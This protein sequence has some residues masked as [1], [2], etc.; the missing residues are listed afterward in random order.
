MK[1]VNILFPNQLFQ[2]SP[3][4]ENNAPFYLVEEFLFFKQYPFHKQKIA[5]HRA[6]MKRY[7]D[8]LQNEKNLEVHYVESTDKNSDIRDLVPALKRLGVDHIHY[9]DPVDNWLQ[10]RLGQG[11]SESG[12][13]GTQYTS[14]MFLN[15]KED[16]SVFFRRDKKKY[17]QTTFYTDQR[18]K[19]NI[20]MDS[21]GKPMGGKWTFDTENRKKYPA[22]KIP[23]A[24]HFPETDSYFEEATSYVKT[25]FSHHLGD[26]TAYSLYPTGFEETSA[27]LDQF[28]EHRF[29]EFGVYEDAIVAENSIL[30]H[31]VLTPMLNVGLITPKEV[32]N[33]CLRYAEVNDVPLNSTEGFVRQII[34]WREFIRGIYE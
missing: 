33:R 9:I 11:L 3:L 24:I 25:H 31:S 1:Q 7:A 22:K 15:S 28:F 17:H 14:P 26:L 23:P 18:K 4:F 5:F 27:W 32:V 12:I 19:R 10:K 8:F 16:L 34:G 2:E 30:N 20:L 13:Q 6:T 21:D 29:S